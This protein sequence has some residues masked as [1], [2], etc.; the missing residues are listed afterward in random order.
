[1]GN[2]LAD[3]EDVEIGDLLKREVSRLEK[4]ILE[5]SSGAQPAAQTQ[6]AA[7]TTENTL[8][9]QSTIDNLTKR[10]QDV[11]HNKD[12]EASLTQHTNQL[13]DLI[14]KVDTRVASIEK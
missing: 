2:R 12:T 10:L 11:E 4:M 8:M 13:K 14:G 5:G 1:M 7:I 9:M 3:L 6:G